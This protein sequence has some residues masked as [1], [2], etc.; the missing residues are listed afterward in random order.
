MQIRWHTKYVEDRMEQT[1]LKLICIFECLL[2][3]QRV[4]MVIFSSSFGRSPVG[5][6]RVRK[7]AALKSWSAVCPGHA[8]VS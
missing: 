1:A 5:R 8:V 6:T 4:S 2:V 3:K 7:E